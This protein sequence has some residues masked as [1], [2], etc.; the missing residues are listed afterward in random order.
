MHIKY[1]RAVLRHKMFV[2]LAGWGEVGIW[3]LLVHDLSKFLPCE[4][5]AYARKFYGGPYPSI[6]EFHGDVRN[7]Y[8]SAGCYR[9][10]IDD[11]FDR[12]WLHHQHANPHHWQH[13]VLREDSGAT[14]LLPMPDKY[15]REM[16]ADWRGAG[17]AYGNNDTPGWYE[18]NAANIM[19]HPETRNWV[20]SQLGL[21]YCPTCGSNA[22]PCICDIADRFGVPG[23]MKVG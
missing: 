14:K 6:Y 22:D 23:A 8:L 12:A 1:L 9:E 3:Q 17:R 16:L 21:H 4:W 10:K 18:R 5:F 7:M 11:D 2:L 19:L 13:Y 15:R 20:I